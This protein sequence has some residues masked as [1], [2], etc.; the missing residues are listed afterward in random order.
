[1]SIEVSSKSIVSKSNQDYEN[2]SKKDL[3]DMYS[4]V[5]EKFPE[6]PKKYE[7]LQEITDQQIYKTLKNKDHIKKIN[8]EI[9]SLYVKEKLTEFEKSRIVQLQN[10][11]KDLIS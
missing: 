8:Q 1:M 3:I 10:I 6:N 2:L 4:V 5:L 7:I 9:K 11:L